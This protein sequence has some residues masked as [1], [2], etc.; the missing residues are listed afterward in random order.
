MG[1]AADIADLLQQ[2]GGWGLSTLCMTAILVLVRYI[3]AQ[4]E[5]RLKDQ[6][7]RNEK[8]MIL[9]EGRVEADIKYEQALIS[10]TASLGSMKCPP[11]MISKV[12]E[13]HM[14]HAQKDAD[15]VPI[16]YVR[17]SLKDQLTHISKTVDTLCVNCPSVE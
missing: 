16:W 4:H 14:W 9:M 6:D 13:L 7:E 17:E 15:G 2:Y 11:D 5:S 10:L 1:A 3:R 8:L 12:E